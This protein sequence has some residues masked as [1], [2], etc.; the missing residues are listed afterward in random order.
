[1]VSSAVQ[2]IYDHARIAKALVVLAEADDARVKEAV[3][4]IESERLA[5]LLLLE[6]SSFSKLTEQ[7]Q[8]DLSG[9][10][11][12]ARIKNVAD[13]AAARKLLSA[14]TK[15]L[16]AALVKAGKADGY[17]A[18]NK[19]A[20]SETIRPALKIIG[21]TG[22]ASSFFIMLYHGTPLFF[23]D[24]GFVPAPNPEQL[25]KIAIDTA[26]NAT[27]F[28]IEPRVA[29]LSFSTAG[30]AQHESIDSV[31]KAIAL[32]RSA[33]L[34]IAIAESE[35]QFDAAF[36]P[37]VAARKVPGMQVAGHANVFIFPDLNSGN[38]AY[39]IAER[40]GGAQAI[41]PIFQGF[42]APVNDLSRGCKVQDIVDVVAV[43]AMQ[44]GALKKAREEKTS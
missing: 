6:E 39:K 44:A 33:A 11:V 35:L 37:D 17:V 7:E 22:L 20:T 10:V 15:Y 28:G 27:A 21:T 42:K 4:V 5:R 40:M 25:A 14:D 12:N 19:C 9:V 26:R 38:I 30:S 1:M 18:G 3:P 16:A 41:G 8:A 32:A 31:R 43:T 23:A 29:F 34:N 36:D 24:C 13:D 2:T